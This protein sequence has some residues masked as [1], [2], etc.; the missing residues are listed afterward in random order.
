MDGGRRSLRRDE[1]CSSDCHTDSVGDSEARG[2]A[3]G[4][5]AAGW[6]EE[7]E[8]VRAGVGVVDGEAGRAEVADGVSTAVM[9][10]GLVVMLA[11]YR[12]PPSRRAGR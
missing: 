6:G 8:V 7:V 2:E 4:D 12:L 5:E 3:E 1:R 9:M 10:C 11:S